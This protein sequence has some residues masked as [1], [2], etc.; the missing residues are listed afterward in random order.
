[1]AEALKRQYDIVALRVAMSN[2]SRNDV[3][4]TLQAKV[5]DELR[6]LK[7]WRTTVDALGLDS[8][9]GQRPTQRVLD[10]PDLPGRMLAFIR[11]YYETDP[12]GRRP[13]WVHVVA[14]YGALRFVAW[15]RVLGRALSV[16]VLMLPD[17]I[18]P[19]PL[20]TEE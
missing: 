20:D 14:P 12:R 9:S 4:F 19:P 11:N 16:P 6:D 13:L 5:D 18:F 8:H 17:F 7:S 2:A 10:R 1:M 15:E 3:T